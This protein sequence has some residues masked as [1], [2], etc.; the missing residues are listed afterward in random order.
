MS[1]N[2]VKLTKEEKKKL[3][4]EKKKNANP[5]VK[6]AIIFS[7][8]IVIVM[9]LVGV[10]LV[11]LFKGEETKPAEGEKKTLNSLEKYGYTLDDK[12]TEIYK[13][14]FNKLKDNLESKEIDYEEYAKSIAKLFVIDLY[15][16]SNK[17]NKYDVGGKE[18]VF[19]DARENY[20]LN[21]EDTIYRY[22]EDNSDGKRNQTLPTISSVEIESITTTTFKYT[23]DTDKNVNK[24]YE[25]YT[26]KYKAEYETA[27]SGYDTSGE[28][29]IVKD[30]EFLYVIEKK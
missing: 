1:K 16:I 18:F 20:E 27:S 26:V 11:F 22:V 2:K 30:G 13:T 3:K 9:V 19:P 14:E 15:T 6:P 4:D 7:I 25:A 29:T 5:I 17:T 8:I 23:P 10:A 21:V 24:E 28:I 12:D